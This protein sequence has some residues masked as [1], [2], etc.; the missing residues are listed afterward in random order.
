MSRN[1][2]R[3]EQEQPQAAQ[4]DTNTILQAILAIAQN[5]AK[6]TDALV[7]Q[8]E[9]TAPKE[10]PNYKAVGAF[11]KETGEPYAADLKCLIYDGPVQL[12]RTPLTQIEVEQLNR[13]QPLE[14][15][16]ITKVDRSVVKASVVPT[17]DA[18]GKLAKLEIKRPMG[19][20]DNAQHYPPLDE[21]A[22]QLA[23]QAA[24]Q[25]QVAA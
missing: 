23:D 12:N 9:R 11:H 6:Q 10:N 8:T 25:E 24:A 7:T 20:D 14:K 1:R 17:F 13:L 15:G 3:D 16:A 22:R 21:I 19:R 4:L 5:Q 18:Q 2:E